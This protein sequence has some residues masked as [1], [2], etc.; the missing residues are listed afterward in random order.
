MIL[1]LQW[2]F[3]LHIE[4][5]LKNDAQLLTAHYY[6]IF[7]KIKNLLEPAMF[8]HLAVLVKIRQGTIPTVHGKKRV[9][10]F[11]YTKHNIFLG[12]DL[13]LKI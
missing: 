1:I 2:F 5:V 4:I 8:Y 6:F 10:E 13:L 12:V 7:T 3:L 11:L 9:Q